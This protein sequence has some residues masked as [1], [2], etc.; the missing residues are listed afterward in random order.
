MAN[1]QYRYVKNS[2]FIF[3]CYLSAVTS[4][5]IF[6]SYIKNY[7]GLFTELQNTFYFQQSEINKYDQIF[8]GLHPVNNLLAG[9]KVRPVSKLTQ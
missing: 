1:G 9:D 5:L 7:N 8:E 2:L 4:L 3:T 6:C